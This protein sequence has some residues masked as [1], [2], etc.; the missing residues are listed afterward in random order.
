MPTNSQRRWNKL[1]WG[2]EKDGLRV[3]LKNRFISE[4]TAFFPPFP[5][6]WSRGTGGDRGGRFLN[7]VQDFFSLPPPDLSKIA[8]ESGKWVF[9]DSEKRNL[10]AS[11]RNFDLGS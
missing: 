10:R 8:L 9:N 4:T 1:F 7:L 5:R 3:T 11:S 2:G 6:R